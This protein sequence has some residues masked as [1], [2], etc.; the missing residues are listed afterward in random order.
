[1]KEAIKERATKATGKNVDFLNNRLYVKLSLI[2]K[3][4]IRKPI[5]AKVTLII[6]TILVVRLFINVFNVVSSILMK[7]RGGIFIKCK[8]KKTRATHKTTTYHYYGRL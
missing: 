1:M 4:A 3:F 6:V 2:A 7:L 8:A 5:T